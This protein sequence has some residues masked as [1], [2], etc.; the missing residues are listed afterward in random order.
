MPQDLTDD[1][2]TLVQVLAWCRQATSYYLNQCW[3]SSVSPY[4]VTRDQWANN[5]TWQQK[6]WSSLMQMIDGKLPD[7][8]QVK[9]ESPYLISYGVIFINIS[10]TMNGIMIIYLQNSFESW[11]KMSMESLIFKFRSS[12]ETQLW[13]TTYHLLILQSCRKWFHI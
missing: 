13:L 9:K 7:W 6:F 1:K 11:L 5:A 3:L 8:Q 10:G 2:S 12:T 4:G